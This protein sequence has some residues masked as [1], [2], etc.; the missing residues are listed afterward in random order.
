MNL[1]SLAAVFAVQMTFVY[2][3]LRP[4]PLEQLGGLALALT[5]LSLSGIRML[6][7]R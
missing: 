6:K 7:L 1:K 2:V 5:V 3:A 4:M